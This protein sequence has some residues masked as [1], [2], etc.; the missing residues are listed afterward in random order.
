MRER[1]KPCVPVVE[2]AVGAQRF[3][4]RPQDTHAMSTAWRKSEGGEEWARTRAK[5]PRAEQ[6]LAGDRSGDGRV[7]IRRPAE[8]AG[9]SEMGGEEGSI[10]ARPSGA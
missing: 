9:L 5:R 1:G 8:N 6:H 10:A 7:Q 2:G 3:T 4:T